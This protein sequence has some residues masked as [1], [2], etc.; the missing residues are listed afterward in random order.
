MGPAAVW[1]GRALSAALLVSVFAASRVEGF[2]PAP[3]PVL[4]AR[5]AGAAAAASPLGARRLSSPRRALMRS[6]CVRVGLGAR[7]AHSTHVRA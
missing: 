5:V 1:R 6:G 4:R 3:A 7:A 2:A